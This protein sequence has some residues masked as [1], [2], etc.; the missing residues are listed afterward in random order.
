MTAEV[1][2]LTLWPAAE[3]PESITV[4]AILLGHA[5]QL[6]MHVLLGLLQH[7]DQVGGLLFVFLGEERVSDTL[8]LTTTSTTDT[9]GGGEEKI[10]KRSTANKANQTG[11]LTGE[12]SL[13]S[14]SDNRN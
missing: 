7:L 9:V 10:R 11:T 5:E 6:R 12:R 4:T 8:V 14:S 3:L 1:V 13:P 2:A